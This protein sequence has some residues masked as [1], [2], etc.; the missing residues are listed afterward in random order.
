MEIS[1]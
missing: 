1:G